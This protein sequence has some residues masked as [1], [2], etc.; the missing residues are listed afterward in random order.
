MKV[1]IADDHVIVRRGIQQILRDAFDDLTCGEA[2]DADQAIDLARAQDWDVVILDISMPGRSGLEALKEIKKTRPNLPVLVLSIHPEDQFAAR[3]LKAGA[4][5]YMTKESA[6]DDLVDAINK[7]IAGRKY[8]SATFAEQLA[9]GLTRE[10]NGS[11]LHQRLSDRE[12]EVLLLIAAGNN[13]TAIAEKLS[14]SI[15]T[16]STYRTRILEKTG[17]KNNADLIRYA[18]ANRL[19]E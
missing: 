1:L 5:G 14:L 8:I 13:L 15:K 10:H 12:Y 17:M 16:I 11:P 3:A 4:S 7:A 6:P 9:D 19:V 18:I 2:T